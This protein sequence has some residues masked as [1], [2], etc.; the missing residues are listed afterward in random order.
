MVEEVEVDDDEKDN[1]DDGAGNDDGNVNVMGNLD[2]TRITPQ[3]ENECLQRLK[4]EMDEYER[5][6]DGLLGNG[7]HKRNDELCIFAKKIMKCLMKKVE[8]HF[9]A[10]WFPEDGG[11]RDGYQASLNAHCTGWGIL[12]NEIIKRNVIKK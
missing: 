11:V 9:Y 3:R 1:N 7:W 4:K 5:I 6:M 12:M 2:I 8:M 10:Y